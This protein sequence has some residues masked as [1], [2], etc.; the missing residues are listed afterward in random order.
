MTR[1]YC[2]DVAVANV[3]GLCAAPRNHGKPWSEA[4]VHAL[5]RLFEDGASL[6]HIAT[7]FG[8]TG[9]SI[10]CKLASRGL[11]KRD[12]SLGSWVYVEAS[13]RQPAPQ[14]VTKTQ[15]KENT[16]NLETTP[17]ESRVFVFGVDISKYKPDALISMIGDL[18]E[19]GRRL[20]CLD[21]D[22]SAYVASRLD[23]ID[24]AINA[25][26]KQLDTFAKDAS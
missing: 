1:T 20:A 11:I 25:V 14:P 12:Y 7:H 2:S 18:R 23:D 9:T 13:D 15:P 3:D 22:S 21:V 19:T 26:I 5:H 16:M 17:V 10:V 4:D 24:A 6:P 8:R